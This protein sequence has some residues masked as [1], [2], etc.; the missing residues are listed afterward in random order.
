MSLEKK[1]LALHKKLNGK[2]E[3]KNKAPLKTAA[4]LSLW[5]TPGVAAVS[6]HLAAHK[7]DIW[8][9]T[10]KRNTVAVIS[11]GSAVLGLGNIGYEGALPVMEGKAMIFKTFA[12]IDAVPLVLATQDTKEIVDTIVNISPAFGGINLEDISAPRCFEIEKQLQERLSMPVMHD[13]QHGTAIVVLAGLLNAFRV[14]KKS[15]NNAK[16]VVNGCGPAGAAIIK[17]LAHYGVRELIILDSKGALSGK[18][19]DLHGFKSELAQ[20]TNPNNVSG[21][22]KDALVG[23]DAVIGVSRGNIIFAEHIQLMNDKPIVFALANPTP[24]I[25]PDTAKK[26]GAFIVATGRSDFPNQINNALVYP[27]VFRGALDRRVPRIT[28]DMKIRAA[29]KLASLVRRPSTN[30]IVPSMFDKRVVPTI[31]SAIY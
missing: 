2:I 24:E 18:R 1:A 30:A 17:L 12:G 26:A 14:A 6:T 10:M 25:M 15:L 21:E 8:H 9:Y 5:Y 13:D 31:A 20:L 16:V 27:G 29:K 11:D 28:I 7:G 3:M 4:D 19:S 23:A 22:L